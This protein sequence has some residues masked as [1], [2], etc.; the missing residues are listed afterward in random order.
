MPQ[1]TP[2]T[3][4]LNQQ[5]PA[6]AIGWTHDEFEQLAVRTT[7]EPARVQAASALFGA[8]L[9]SFAMFKDMLDIRPS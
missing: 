5:Q 1:P 2:S 7:H 9:I 6:N 3:N 8:R 4:S